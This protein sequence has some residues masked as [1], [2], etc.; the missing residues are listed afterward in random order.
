MTITC[1]SLLTVTCKTETKQGTTKHKQ[2]QQNSNNAQLKHERHH[3][4]HF[5][6]ALLH[7]SILCSM[8]EVG[9]TSLLVCITVQ[10]F[11]C[12]QVSLMAVHL[13]STLIWSPSWTDFCA[14]VSCHPH[15]A[16][17]LFAFLA[18]SFVRATF[19]SEISVF[20]RTSFFSVVHCQRVS[21][22]VH[23]S[24]FDLHINVSD[25]VIVVNTTAVS[26]LSSLPSLWQ[27]RRFYRGRS[28]RHGYQLYFRFHEGSRQL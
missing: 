2:A 13:P 24:T 20:G 22:N 21:H 6:W 27:S 3:H 23:R 25:Q 1:C 7:L 19:V 4:H 26:S 10:F 14:D 11:V 8:V 15:V 9:S 28:H 18:L 12:S 16:A 17:S 5:F